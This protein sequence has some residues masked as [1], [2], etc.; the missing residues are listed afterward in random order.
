GDRDLRAPGGDLEGRLRD[1]L[2]R[3]GRIGGGAARGADD[4]FR[5]GE[6]ADDLHRA[7]GDGDDAP[8][9]DAG[10]AEA[11]GGGGGFE[12][13]GLDAVARGDGARAGGEALPEPDGA[14]REA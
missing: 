13:G 10:L 8:V 14:P 4:K 12:H 3:E 11:E 5:A 9:V 2:G 6:P 1:R 7:P